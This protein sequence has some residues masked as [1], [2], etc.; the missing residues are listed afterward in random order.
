MCGQAFVAVKSANKVSLGTGFDHLQ[1]VIADVFIFQVFDLG[2]N[3]I[4][5]FLRR[6]S[7]EQE[8]VEGEQVRIFVS[9]QAAESGGDRCDL[10]VAHQRA[11]QARGAARGH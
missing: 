3:G 7:G 11:I 4:C 1:F 2:V 8:G 10:L 6:A 9:R 5:G